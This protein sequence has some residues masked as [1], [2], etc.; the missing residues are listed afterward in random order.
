MR[1]IKFDAACLPFLVTANGRFWQIS[2]SR[3][4]A[5]IIL[6]TTCRHRGGPL[7]HGQLEG[8]SI[9]CPW[10]GRLT[11]RCKL[12]EG[13]FAYLRNGQKVQVAMPDFQTLI[14]L[15]KS[16]AIPS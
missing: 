10:H 13:R 1:I 16:E 4:G 7:T 15:E 5:L 8:D 9:K 12:R 2:S 3:K 6:D 11:A 14:N